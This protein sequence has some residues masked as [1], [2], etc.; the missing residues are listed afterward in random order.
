MTVM[1]NEGAWGINP[2]TRLNQSKHYIL[3]CLLIKIYVEMY[4]EA[5]ICIWTKLI[6][7]MEKIEW[8]EQRKIK[9][10]IKHEGSN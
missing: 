5:Y 2:S 4:D 6:C 8:I 7:E 10:Q 1:K 9:S 3:F